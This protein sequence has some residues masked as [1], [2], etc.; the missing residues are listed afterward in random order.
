MANIVGKK[1]RDGKEEELRLGSFYAEIA[2]RFSGLE[3]VF[4]MSKHPRSPLHF[5]GNGEL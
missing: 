4:V 3:G 1:G 5:Y 2:I